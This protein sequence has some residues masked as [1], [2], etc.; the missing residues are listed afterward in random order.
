MSDITAIILAGGK[1][2][3]FDNQ[4]K[5]LL[6]YDDR[7]FME[8]I[9]EELSKVTNDII[10]SANTT[11]YNYLNYPVY[12]DIIPDKGPMGGLFTGLTVSK[13]QTNLVIACDMPFI[14]SDFLYDLS[15]QL[16]DYDAVIP[17]TSNRKHPLYGCY[18]KNC[19]YQIHHLLR[20]NI[21]KMQDLF[22]FLSIKYIEIDEP[23]STQNIKQVS[24][25]NTLEDYNKIINS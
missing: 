24:N 20:K 18:S 22:N 6:K 15:R 12:P 3:R 8:V 5:G 14:S 21:L 17:I 19:I 7:N 13:N 2:K 23:L 16:Q 4:A 9:T 25:I 11:D 1:G 10:I